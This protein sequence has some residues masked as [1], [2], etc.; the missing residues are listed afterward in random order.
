MLTL[1]GASTYSGG[2]TLSAGE[3]KIGAS[4]ASSGSGPIGTG[5]LTLSGGT[6]SSNSTTAYSLYFNNVS[7]TGNV[8]FGD[9]TNTGTLSFNGSSGNFT[10]NTSNPTLTLNNAPVS[11]YGL[12]GSNNF[13]LS[14]ANATA[15][16]LTIGGVSTGYTGQITVTGS[17]STPA[18]LAFAYG[19][20]N[21]TML[22]GSGSSVLVNGSGNVTVSQDYEALGNTTVN[23]NSS[24]ATF[25][26]SI[27][28]YKMLFG[29]LAGV[30]DVNLVASSA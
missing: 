23:L 19:S 4:S 27:G 15:R 29:G 3:L 18:N 24:T 22:L 28:G 5:T 6:I 14:G 12:S 20:N 17:S 21:T 25:T 26:D 8:T 10:I 30:A 9:G 11:L 16:S 1:S 2:T 7:V 13:T